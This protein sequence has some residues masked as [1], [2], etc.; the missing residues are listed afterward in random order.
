[1]RW[2]SL[3]KDWAV[4]LP[5]NRLDHAVGQV[6]E[7]CHVHRLDAFRIFGLQLL[8]STSLHFFWRKRIQWPRLMQ[9][10][11]ATSIHI[12]NRTGRR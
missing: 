8:G 7:Q 12:K 10:C 6:R 9:L 3:V 11:A 1:M 4:D 5:T 2:V